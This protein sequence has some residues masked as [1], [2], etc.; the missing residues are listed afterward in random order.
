MSRNWEEMGIAWDMSEVATQAGD[1]A[2]DKRTLGSIPVP[3]LTNI[4]KAIASG[5]ENA[6]LTGINGT[7]WR[8]KAQDVGRRALEK[9]HKV[10]RELL[11]DAIFARLQSMRVAS[12]GTVR[13]VREHR[14]PD[15]TLYEG[16]LEIEFRSETMAQYV[17]LGVSV[18]VAQKL[19]ESLVW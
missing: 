19:A 5:L 3:R 16:T 10:D 8:V 14:L 1:H 13:V 15:G 4:A 18:E 7:S 2:T 11:K 12:V 9:N 17:D 6:I